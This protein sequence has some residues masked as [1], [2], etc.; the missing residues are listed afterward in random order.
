MPNKN[1]ANVANA[2]PKGCLWQPHNRQN[3]TEHDKTSSKPKSSFAAELSGNPGDGGNPAEDS[4]VTFTEKIR[5]DNMPI[6]VKSTGFCDNAVTKCL[7]VLISLH[8]FKIFRA[9][10][11]EKH[12]SRV[13]YCKDCNI[14]SRCFNRDQAVNKLQT[15]R[16]STNISTREQNR[17][18]T[19]T[20]CWQRLSARQGTAWP[21]HPTRRRGLLWQRALLN[22]SHRNTNLGKN[23]EQSL[24]NA[25]GKDWERLRE[26]TLA[27]QNMAK[28]CRTKY[29]LNS[30]KG[31]CCG[32]FWKPWGWWKSRRGLCCHLRRKKVEEIRASNGNLYTPVCHQR[33][34]KK[35]SI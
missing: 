35:N 19:S 1:L 22:S 29:R 32:G 5:A 18:Y 25:S 2:R 6:M 24:A 34:N 13:N 12:D 3:M 7:K 10:P 31:L 30:T 33:R 8:C 26:K 21:L 17:L 28:C 11:I 16:A 14:A 27:C 4:A 15:V 23:P 9:Q 20:S